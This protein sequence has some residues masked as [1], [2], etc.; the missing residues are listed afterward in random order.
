[1]NRKIVTFVVI[2]VIAVTGGFFWIKSRFDAQVRQ[3]I[4]TFV[5][6][7]PAP[8]TM[9]IGKIDVDS[10]K[11]TVTLFDAETICTSNNGEQKFSAKRVVAANVNMDA[12]KEG[13]GKTVLLKKLELA[14]VAFMGPGLAGSMEYY[15]LE[16]IA[17]DM[18]I[19]WPAISRALPGL[20]LAY[21]RL[22]DLETNKEL[23]R[24]LMAA[25]VDVLRAYETVAIDTFEMRNYTYRLNADDMPLSMTV[26]D[27]MGSK[28]ALRDMGPIQLAGISVTLGDT[29][30][31]SM[32]SMGL[33]GAKLPSFVPLFEIAASGREPALSEIQE[34]FKAKDFSLKN[35]Y[36][37]NML[38]QDPRQPG[39][40]ICSLAES[41][42]SYDGSAMHHAA[43]AWKDLSVNKAL[44][45]E[46]SGLSAGVLALIPD[47]VHVGG[48]FV[49]QAATKDKG[50]Y[51][52]TWEAM[53]KEQA[54]G[55]LLIKADVLNVHAM[56]VAMGSPGA[57][58]LGSMTLLATDTGISEILFTLAAEK[59][60]VTAEE[61]RASVVRQ[62][63]RSQGALPNDTIRN[64]AENI[65]KFLEKPGSSITVSLKPESP[66]NALLLKQLFVADP[67]KLGLSVSLTPAQ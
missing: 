58:A 19:I 4:E 39:Q 37:K 67:V 28:Y 64:L 13:A 63:S 11:R 43:I 21:N 40:M 6:S 15:R 48:S 49:V 10:F 50:F 26:R 53:V 41:S 62:L 12:F 60:G 30:V 65:M 23:Q 66:L 52:I 42:F 18:K 57:A 32:E 36:S 14:D 17:G 56:A 25:F 45:T 22:D 54:L 1:M 47:T 20:A 44:Y 31:L 2:A 61:Q 16:G 29:P 9:T 59:E 35:V 38:V 5:A 55:S 27:V 7:I 33:E 51:D 3:G 46:G 34:V 24:K 8:C